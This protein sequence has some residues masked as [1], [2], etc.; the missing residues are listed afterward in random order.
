MCIYIRVVTVYTYIIVYTYVLGTYI[1]TYIQWI[2]TCIIYI[3]IRIN[4]HIYMY[5]FMYS[6]TKSQGGYSIIETFEGVSQC[7]AVCCRVLQCVA[8]CCSALQCVAV[9]CSVLQCVHEKLLGIQR[10]SNPCT[11][12]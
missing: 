12:N 2:Y 7:V 9:C 11:A 3:Y 8:V 10:E 4:I 5:V 6:C 1:H